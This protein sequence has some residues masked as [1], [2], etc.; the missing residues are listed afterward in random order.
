MY[1][2]RGPRASAVLALI[3]GA[4]STATASPAGSGSNGTPSTL[5]CSAEQF[6]YVIVG[7]GLSGL[8]VANRLSENSKGYF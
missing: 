7:G 2:L 6:D 5:N 1:L 4:I 8:V 3:L